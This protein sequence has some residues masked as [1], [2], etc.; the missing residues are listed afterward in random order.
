MCVDDMHTWQWG[1]TSVNALCCRESMTAR[2]LV[3]MGADAHS[4]IDTHMRGH[5]RVQNAGRIINTYVSLSSQAMHV[6]LTVSCKESKQSSGVMPGTLFIYLF[7]FVKINERRFFN[8]YGITHVVQMRE[9]DLDWGHQEPGIRL[10]HYRDNLRVQQGGV[11]EERDNSV[12]HECF[13]FSY[14]SKV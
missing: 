3:K 8:F 14:L 7:F 2:W 1:Q 13:F 9:L 4:F 6:S 12:R 5:P 11:A 10:H